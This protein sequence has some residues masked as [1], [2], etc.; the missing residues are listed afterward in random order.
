MTHHA[1]A[2]L[3]ELMQASDI[4]D[5][6]LASATQ[7]AKSN[8]SRLK[9]DPQSNPTLAT[10][11][12]IADYFNITVSQLLGEVPLKRSASRRQKVPILSLDTV[13]AYRKGTITEACDWFTTEVKVSKDA[14]A[15]RIDDSDIASVFPAKTH[16]LIDSRDSYPTNCYVLIFEG[17]E[18]V[19]VFRQYIKDGQHIIL[20]SLKAELSLTHALDDSILIVGMV[21]EVRYSDV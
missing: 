15:I 1:G 7:V 4:D 11:K 13:G 5:T 14:F 9:N 18:K 21:L 10:L 17:E 8:I 6:M 16:L 12:P 3:K 19:P 20:K 2:C